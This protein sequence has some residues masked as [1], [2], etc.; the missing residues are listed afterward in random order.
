MRREPSLAEHRLWQ[1]IRAGQANGAKFRRQHA[2]GPYIVDFVCL[3]RGLVVEVDGRIH[4]ARKKYDAERE[5]YLQGAGLKVLRVQ[6]EDVLERLDSVIQRI[7][8]ALSDAQP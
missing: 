8:S 7:E 4:L 5:A 6:N 3:R 1:A 2:I